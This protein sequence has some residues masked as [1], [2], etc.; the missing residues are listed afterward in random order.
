MSHSS[1]TVATEH[2]IA[3]VTLNRPDTRNALDDVMIREMTEAFTFLNRAPDN[4]IV[5][6][7]GAGTSFC[8]GMDLQYLQK[9]SQLGH[10]E[11]LEDA[12]N[13]MKLLQTIH[14]MKRPVIAMVNGP[15]MG[16]GCGIAAACDFVYA[17]KEKA[18][19][20]VP[21][22]RLGFLP[23]LILLFLIKRMGEGKAREFVLRGDVVTPVAAQALGLVT[24]VVEDDRLHATVYEFAGHIANTTS[25]SSIALTKELFSRLQEMNEKE[26]LEYAANLNALARKTDDFRKG[27]DSFIT[28]EKLQ[29]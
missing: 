15:A 24:E 19:L 16:G 26:M 12:K 25:G 5:V 28:K 9:Y 4:R 17:G 21:E 6:L 8:A 7:T 20:G 23:A 2:R 27:I 29:W 22:V 13:L 11:N 10:G 1:I 3:T 14:N 18:R